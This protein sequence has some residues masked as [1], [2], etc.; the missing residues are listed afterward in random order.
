MV[1]GFSST[2]GGIQISMTNFDKINYDPVT[3]LLSVGAGALWGPVY[4][5]TSKLARCVVGGANPAVGVA[6]FV[7]GGGYSL[8][9]NRLGLACD[10]VQAFRIVTTDGKVHEVSRESTG[11]DLELYQALRVCDFIRS[12]PS[13]Y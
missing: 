12:P 9:T 13:S 2:Y 4:Q 5:Y 3:T 7:L 10:R 11:A 6:G 8:K 1:P